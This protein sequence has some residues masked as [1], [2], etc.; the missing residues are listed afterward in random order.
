MS[1]SPLIL[2]AVLALAPL[3]AR[4]RTQPPTLKVHISV[5]MEGVA[6][7]VTGDQLGPSGFEYG[8][9]RE[10]MTREALAAVTAAREAGATEI[11]VADSHGNGENLLIEQFPPDVRLV[12]SWPRKL[13]M[14]AG[15]DGTFDA[16][17]F[18][19]YHASTTNPA[20]VRAHTNSSATLTR[21]ALNGVDMTE[22]AWNAAIAGHFGVP[23]VMISGDDAA[24]AEVRGVIGP[25]EAAETKKALGFHSAMTL[26]PQAALD[27]IGPRVKAGLARRTEL[28]P[29][30]PAEPV[31]VDVGFKHYLPAEV[32][33]Y[34]PMFERTG[35]HSIRFRAKDMVEA[36]SVME[37][38]GE[39]RPDLTP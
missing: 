29:Y 30:R 20:G 31:T 22:G 39:Y 12:R 35:S 1:R 2:L 27:L 8:R 4:A 26:T 24:V 11:V 23:V 14:M 7:V 36:S 10:F 28:K 6:G 3:A 37:F 19:G 9:F 18:I 21:V 17:V 25:I 34:L 38:I 15:I 16:A 33:A 32:L 13:S 5:D